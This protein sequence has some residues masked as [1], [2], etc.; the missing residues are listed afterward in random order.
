MSERNTILN[1]LKNVLHFDS[2]NDR[3]ATEIERGCYAATREECVS[4]PLMSDRFMA[5]YSAIAYRV[6]N[7]L[8]N[9]C[10][11]HARIAAGE[12]ELSRLAFMRAEELD[13]AANAAIRAEIAL[14]SGVEIERV[15]CTMYTCAR[16][17][18]NKTDGGQEQQR[19]AA[20]EGTSLK[21]RCLA[22]GHRWQIG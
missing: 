16:C 22:C 20:D 13:P 15:V 2:D 3:M 11:L 17:G 18:Q 19:R 6:S 14:R 1:M 10:E 4:E 7:A 21:I 12:V 8:A 9:S 5:A